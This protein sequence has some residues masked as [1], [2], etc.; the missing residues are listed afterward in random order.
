M[1]A[2]RLTFIAAFLLSYF[3]HSQNVTDL[4]DD[5]TIND[6]VETPCQDIIVEGGFDGLTFRYIDCN[7]NTTGVY[8]PP[9][10]AYV[11]K[12]L[13][14]TV[15]VK[16]GQFIPQ[17]VISEPV[18][19]TQYVSALQDVIEEALVQQLGSID[20]YIDTTTQNI[21]AGDQPSKILGREGQFF[22]FDVSYSWLKSSD[23]LN[24]YYIKG[25]TQKNYSPGV[26]DQTSYFKRQIYTA[27]ST[28]TYS[29][30]AMITVSDCG[31]NCSNPPQLNLTSAPGTINQV[32]CDAT[33]ISTIV[34][35][36]GGAANQ[37]SF[38]W[39][40]DN[41]LAGSG[42]TTTISGTSQYIIA[43][44]PTT[45]VTQSTVYTYQ[46]ET[47]GSA[48]GTEVIQTGSIQIDPGDQIALVSVPGT[49]NQ[50][51]CLMDNDNPQNSIAESFIPIEYQLQGGA[52][53]N[54][55]QVRYNVGGGPFEA[56]LPAGL[57]YTIT[58]SN[59]IIING[60]VTASTTFVS[61]TVVYNYEISTDGFCSTVMVNGSITVHSPPVL[62]LTSAVTTTNQVGFLNVC[63]QIDPIADIVYTLVDGATNYSF[64][65]TGRNVLNGVNHALDPMTNQVRISGTPSVNVTTTTLYPYRIETTGSACA[66]EVVYT[67]A[68]EVKPIEQL[69]LASTA[70][71]TNQSICVG[72]SFNTL[73]P[74]IYN[75]G[76]EATGAVVTFNPPLPGMGYTLTSTQVIINGFASASA[77]V[78][79]TPVTYLYEVR[80]T[81]C[82][83][84]VENGTITVHPMPVLNLTS[85]P[86]TVSQTVVDQS[87]PITD[88]LYTYEGGAT[89]VVFSW[90][91]SNVLNGIN[92]LTSNDQLIIS[93]TPSTNVTQST[94][95]PY[96]I[97]TVG[98]ACGPEVVLTGIITVNPSSDNA[99]DGLNQLFDINVN[100]TDIGCAGPNF[101]FYEFNISGNSRAAN[102]FEEGGILELNIYE[103]GGAYNLIINVDKL[104]NVSRTLSIPKT[105]HYS[106]NGLT[107]FGE[108]CSV[109]TGTFTINSPDNISI[110]STVISGALNQTVTDSTDI[111]TTTVEFTSSCTD[112]MVIS[113]YDLPTG[114][115][116][117]VTSNS[118]T[119]YGTPSNQASGAYNYSIVATNTSGTA[120][121]TLNGV[122]TI[123]S[124]S[125]SCTIS[126]TLTSAAGTDSQTVSSSSSIT[127]IE[128]T[129]STTCSDTLNAAITWTPST[130]DGISMNF[131]NNVATISGT[132]SG[133]ATGTYN[134]TITA[135][136]SAGT[137]SA[138]FDG[139]LT[140]SPSI[141][142]STT[143]SQTSSKFNYPMEMDF[144]SNGNLFVVDRRNSKV[145][146]ITPEG[147]VTTFASNLGNPTSLSI[148]TNDNLFVG[149]DLGEEANRRVI[150]KINTEGD[151]SIFSGSYEGNIDGNIS[152]ARFSSINS[153]DFDL[154]GN[155][156]V[157]DN[158]NGSIRKISTQGEVTTVGTNF[159]GP[160]GLSFN[161]TKNE[162]FLADNGNFR[163]L[164]FD[165]DSSSGEISST[166]TI[167]E[168]SSCSN[169]SPVSIALDSNDKIYFTVGC[170]P[171]R[172]Y[173]INDDGTESYFS[174]FSGDGQCYLK[175][176]SSDNLYVSDPG[177]DKIYK[178][179]S[180][181]VISIFAGSTAG[182]QDSISTVSSTSSSCTISGTL[183]SAAGTDSQTVS[184]SS[185]IT[186]IEYTLSTTCSDT[187][188][189]AI[190]WTPSTPDGI[191]MNF[192]NNVATI[193]G[194]LSGTATGTYNYTIT[195]SNSA[196]T[197]SATFSGSLTVSSSSSTTSNCTDYSN[198]TIT[199][200]YDEL[201]NARHASYSQ[202]NIPDQTVD[203][204]DERNFQSYWLYFGRSCN[205][206]NSNI[207][208]EVELKVDG[209]AE[210]EYDPNNQNEN[211]I[212]YIRTTDANG[213]AWIVERGNM[214]SNRIMILGQVS[215]TVA[216]Y[217]YTILATDTLSSKTA[218]LTGRI[219]VI[220]SSSNSSTCSITSTVIS[221]ALSQTVTES[222]SIATTTVEFT[223]SC[224]DT[225]VISAYDLPPGIQTAVTSNSI[226]LYGT[227]SNQASGTYNY[228]IVATNTSGTATETV[229]GVVTITQVGTNCQINISFNIQD[230]EL[231]PGW[232]MPR[233]R[234]AG[235]GHG[236]VSL[237]DGC[238]DGYSD[239]SAAISGEMPDEFVF[240]MDDCAGEGYFQIKGIANNS[241]VGVYPLI[242]NFSFGSSSVT[243]SFTLRILPDNISPIIQLNGSSTIN[244]FVGETFNDPGTTSSDEVEVNV[245][246][247]AFN[248][249]AIISGSVDTSNIGTYTLIYTV[250]DA[251]SNSVS[252]TRTVIVK[253][254]P[255]SSCTISGTLTSIA[256]SDS[257]TVL[258]SSSIT[259]IEY[260]L[261]TPCS[262]TLN[263]AITWTPNTPDGVSMSF[264]NNVATI[265]GTLSE[266]ATGT[267]N[268]TLTASNTVGTASATFSGSLTVSST[269]STTSNCTD[270]SN[271]TITGYYDEL[272]NNSLPSYSQT[273]IPDQTVDLA[274]E[275][276]FN[277]YWLY[278]GRNCNGINSNITGEVELKVDGLAEYDSDNEN[279][280]QYFR[281]TEGDG[282]VWMYERGNMESNRI[283][284]LGQVSS[285]VATYTYTILATDTL[286]SKTASLTGRIIVI[287]SSLNSS[288]CSITSSVTSGALSQT[289]TESTSIATTTVEFTS[290]CTDTMVISA[291][292]LPP[293]IETSITSNSII[294]YGRPSNQASGTYNYSIVATNTSGT[295]TETLNGVFT[296]SSTSNSCTIS[297]TLTSAAGTDSQTVSSSSSITAI[298]YTLSTTC[299]DTLNAAIT[300]TPSTPNGISMSFSN[301]VA[302]ISGTLSG[303]ATGT[304]NYTLTA[305]NTAGTA[306]ATFSGSLTV[307]SSTAS[308]T[309]ITGVNDL[310]TGSDLTGRNLIGFDGATMKCENAQVGDYATINGKEYI[311]IDNQ[312]LVDLKQLSNVDYT[313]LCTS[314]VT[315]MSEAFKDNSNFN[316]DI[317]LWDT[318]N[319][320]NMYYMF[321][322][323]EQF[324]QPV[325]SWDVS[326]V[327]NMEGMLMGT[328][329]FNQPIG[330]WDTSNVTNM[331]EMLSGYYGYHQSFNQDIGSWD[332]SNVTSMKGMFKFQ[333]TFNQDIGNWNTSK[334]TSMEYMFW[335]ALSF[336]QNI[337]NWDVSNV[338]DMSKMFS[339]NGEQGGM[340][341]NQDIGNWDVSNVTDMELMF[342]DCPSFNQ[343]LSGWCVSKIGSEPSFSEGSALSNENKPI[344][345]TCPGSDPPPVVTDKIYFENGTCKCPDANVGEIA[346]INSIT[347]TVVDNTTIKHKINNGNVNICTTLVTNMKGLFRDSTLN[348]EIN[349][350][351]TSNV[352]DTSYMF[353]NAT[354]FNKSIDNWDVSN[355][356]DM[357]Y[358][359]ESNGNTHVIFNQDISGW[360]TSS[361]TNM[362]MMFFSNIHFNQPLSLWDVSNVLRMD[363][364]FGY[365]NY[366]QDISDWDVSSCQ[367]F[368]GMFNRN[369]SFNQDISR[370]DVSNAG[371]LFGISDMEAM[372]HE[373]S[374]F[375]QDLSKWCVVNISN[376]PTDFSDNSALTNANKPVWGACPQ[377]YNI[378]V[379]ASGSSNYT[380][381]GTDRSGNVS[382][383]DPAVTINIGDT[384]EFVVTAPGHPF[385]LKTIQ[386]AGTGN[387]ITGITNN[388]TTNGTVSWTPTEAGTYYY[389]CSV[390]NGMYGTITV[391]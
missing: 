193:S 34:Y 84:A 73:T 348:L 324:N 37:L 39:T 374:S 43:G 344:W 300:W 290:S 110:T 353:K 9:G 85:A 194:T 52:I 97:E 93:G 314:K 168:G 306:S 96:Q 292:D 55:I 320:T 153:L 322:G 375:N 330:D 160:Q 386:G 308:G 5:F 236:R 121:E 95:Y 227:P 10:A 175:F 58:P 255:V 75:L 380:L 31:T 272:A 355:V 201:A 280:V 172:I 135:S 347:Y 108:N 136:N 210:Y 337:G 358:M 341:F 241:S 367:R 176:D 166:S 78:S 340:I 286:S 115:Q 80:T 383:G 199:G 304:Y 25:A 354:R 326:N 167:R 277:G 60:A 319:V 129:L 282:Y 179:T 278:F 92:A 369:S 163:I 388:G 190:T 23:G 155:L 87:Q 178:I 219:I 332:V 377:S 133:T 122:F 49:D 42:L 11:L 152:N 391:Q 17:G 112:T 225:M 305:S 288:I 216:T 350:W 125:N 100:V 315:D 328:R 143:T 71:S 359:F 226:T 68:I 83:P 69:T 259:P 41:S 203:L 18:S 284:I 262:D 208:G 2:R 35:Q 188:N 169:G 234:V 170:G 237:S 295:A 159:R 33:P 334:V 67:G 15:D 36:L 361:V 191:S 202:T 212:E 258:S 251:A 378:N 21:C 120:T 61:P 59:T 270:Y 312:A 12:A 327:E 46:I 261:S 140:V 16:Q 299:S 257:Q 372:F 254:Q 148:D 82:G 88:I 90:T 89:N 221:G 14:G 256:G 245:N 389:Q 318:S 119:L 309:S 70:S 105:L 81:G 214:E 130:P 207:T 323:A 390:H 101:G 99:C 381:S 181:G 296:I 138:T 198:S 177:S 183:T 186:A 156:F 215:S 106:I 220:D 173:T 338:R 128:Y 357:S 311:V 289:V 63:N 233:C 157:S 7:C 231:Y 303:T 267:Y 279:V 364:M 102:Y 74:I 118:I 22:D 32:L 302:T 271:S 268:Y 19:N 76:N 54:V 139:S 206:I 316:Q 50:S 132:L 158:N 180:Q 294:L 72:A 275:G 3:L 195:A 385:Y 291:Y 103:L 62:S 384:I 379:T 310:K 266:T 28:G 141:I 182:D 287:D 48:C 217:T 229:T 250:A 222:T 252:T 77:Q 26:L 274:G 24:Y 147:I 47:I 6:C 204:A 27:V 107:V 57:G 238:E 228:S 197:A 104:G 366:N 123:S 114:I 297:G 185:S 94:A 335:E 224:T 285:T 144:D 240:N 64:T 20:N 165:Y 53:G 56:G 174:T 142:D 265:S 146:K 213:Y 134:Y 86:V 1:F 248:D 218:S 273:Y 127:A 360:D 51:I 38:T 44:I 242:V 351:D 339:G 371:N 283:M 8:V 211:V 205:G 363:G 333:S 331:I 246:N 65:W 343:D 263:A 232:D 329:N 293:G 349:F 154:N 325:G 164:K 260:T 298:E 79:N 137:A 313:C 113:A 247:Y 126:G 209:L 301:N 151:F 45:N 184:S 192:S 117:S 131:S 307:S 189:A 149:T 269:S 187:L 244:L 249:N 239:I 346:T 161:S 235:G 162:I 145:K 336:D 109:S 40:G 365:S 387:L 13:V 264:G 29:D 111:V 116:T 342:K 382:G 196:G 352:T 4:F 362:S 370:W 91:G 124:T 317:V 281:T 276:G 223:S 253:A 200:Y 66:P 98:S 243:D 356:I 30:V 345:G 368:T 376:Q 321:Y 150:L 373:A 171:N 230:L